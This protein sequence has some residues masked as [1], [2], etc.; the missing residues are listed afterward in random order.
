MR[1]GRP[2]LLVFLPFAAGYYLSYLYRTINAVISA[3]LTSR[4]QGPTIGLPGA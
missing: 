3:E 4:R 1:Y 2:L